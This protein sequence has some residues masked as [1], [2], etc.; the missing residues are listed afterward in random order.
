MLRTKS[1]RFAPA[2]EQEKTVFGAAR[3]GYRTEQV[4]QWLAFMEQQQ[5]KRVCCL[6]TA[7][8]LQRY[9][10]LLRDYLDHFGV[11]CFFWRA[12]D[13]FA[14][15][16]PA[17]LKE[18]LEFLAVAEQCRERV[19]VHCS[20]GVG[21]TGQVLVAW[22]MVQRGMSFEAAIAAVRRSGRNPYEAAIAAPLRWQNPWKVMAEFRA[23]MMSNTTGLSSDMEI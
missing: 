21:R 16:E 15:I 2:S 19:V 20:G 23:L 7:Q 4:Q 3:P 1:Y 11:E 5:V 12:V 14:L 9:D 18:V 6:L 8:Q 10:G 22:L 13:D 17:K